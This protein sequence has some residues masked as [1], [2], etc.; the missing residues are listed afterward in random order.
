MKYLI[1]AWLT[2][3][4]FTMA[5]AFTESYNEISWKGKLPTRIEFII[6]AS[7]LF[8]W[9]ILLGI[10]WRT[11]IPHQINDAKGGELKP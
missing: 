10:L 9:P 1:A 8:L 4:L 11:E 2:G 7:S 3:A 6:F 5:A